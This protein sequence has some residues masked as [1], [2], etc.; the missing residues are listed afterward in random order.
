M[1]EEK[2]L[3]GDLFQLFSQAKLLAVVANICDGNVFGE[4]LEQKCLRL[5]VCFERRAQALI[6]VLQSEYF[7]ISDPNYK[8]QKST[9]LFSILATPLNPIC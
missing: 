1:K 5:Y 9:H 3:T 2:P 8:L 7:S 4:S 6:S